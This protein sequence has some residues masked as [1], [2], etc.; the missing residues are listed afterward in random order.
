MTTANTTANVRIIG[1]I[2]SGAHGTI[3][4]DNRD[5]TCDVEVANAEGHR[6]VVTVSRADLIVAPG[7]TGGTDFHSRAAHAIAV[8]ATMERVALETRPTLWLETD[9]FEV[10]KRAI[11][12]AAVA[13][14]PVLFIGPNA[15]ISQILAGQ[16]GVPSRVVTDVPQDQYGLRRLSLAMRDYAMHVEAPTCPMKGRRGGGTTLEQARTR[17]AEARTRMPANHDMTD[18]AASVWKTACSEL[19]I[20][21]EVVRKRI[22]SVAV[23]CAAL[24][25]NTKIDTADICEAVS[26]WLDRR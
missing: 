17:V 11:V 14:T 18:A 22:V 21:S 25:G 4:K 7:D 24:N 26:Y 19:G 13:H 1:T 10:V 2:N 9:N 23:S 15:D 8:C 16:I 6:Q 3:V 12:V 20:E 5:G